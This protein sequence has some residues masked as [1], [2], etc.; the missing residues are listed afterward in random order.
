ADAIRNGLESL[1][2]PITLTL[3]RVKR[4][5]VAA[6]HAKITAP[7]EQKHRHLKDIEV[8]IDGG[9][10]SDRQRDL[11]KRMFR[12][13]AEAEAAVHDIPIEKVHFHEVGALDS[14]ADFV[15]A[16]IGLDILGVERFTSGPIATGSG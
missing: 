12:R 15:G 7:Q 8:I 9:R 6:T 3:E 5:N 10:L 14:I 16:A 1:R 11:A 2:L 4:C 13:L